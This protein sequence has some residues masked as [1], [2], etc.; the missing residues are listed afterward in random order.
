MVEVASGVGVGVGEL[1]VTTDRRRELVIY[2][3]GSCVGVA[4][5]DAAAGVGGLLHALLPD[6]SIDPERARADPA[7]FV[8]SGVE[9]LLAAAVAAGANPGRLRVAAAG[10]AHMSGIDH[11]RVGERNTAALLA[12][13][14]SAG[15]VPDATDMGGV[16]TRTLRLDVASGT[17]R[18]Q[19]GDSSRVLSA[20]SPWGRGSA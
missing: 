12:S 2:G 14:G 6:T 11:F 3:L 16:A 19:R 4:V 13:L 10:G 15:L 17:V 9:A 7:V 8:D 18:V 5:H 20:G 1:V